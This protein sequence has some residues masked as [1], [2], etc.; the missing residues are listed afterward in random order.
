MHVLQDE[1]ERLLTPVRVARL[2][3]RARDRVRPE[4]FV[5]RAAV[6]VAGESEESRERQDQQGRRERRKARPAKFAGTVRA[7]QFPKM[8][9]AEHKP[10]GAQTQRQAPSEKVPTSPGATSA[11]Q[12]P[13]SN[14]GARGASFPYRPGT[15]GRIR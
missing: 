3:D 12:R 10:A 14:A 11:G 2:T 8:Y 13:T 4:R 1:R 15:K 5:V 9:I 7:K 6:V